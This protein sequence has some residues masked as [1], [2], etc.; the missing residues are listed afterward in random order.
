MAA[1]HHFGFKN[2]QLVIPEYNGWPEQ[3]FQ[4]TCKPKKKLIFHRSRWQYNFYLLGWKVITISISNPFTGS[5]IN[6]KIKIG[7][8]LVFN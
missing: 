1:E 3:G 7:F 6:K 5:V 2:V 8:R 4:K